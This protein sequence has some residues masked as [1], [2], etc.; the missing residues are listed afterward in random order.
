[1]HLRL[2]SLSSEFK[3]FIFHIIFSYDILGNSSSSPLL[4]RLCGS[5]SYT[6]YESSGNSL[7][8]YYHSDH[9][10]NYDDYVLGYLA[11]PGSKY[12]NM[13]PSFPNS[14]LV[15]LYIK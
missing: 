4:D 5:V 15:F 11:V 13:S 1:M 9:V 12:Q 2:L 8:I 14:L 3:L 7:Y 6:E 10:N